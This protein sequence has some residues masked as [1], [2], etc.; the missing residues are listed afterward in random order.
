MSDASIL[1]AALFTPGPRF[2]WGL[3]LRIIGSPGTAKSDIIT[4]VATKA[5]L[6]V[7][8][9]LAS[10]RDPTDFLGMPVVRDGAVT[11]APPDWVSEVSEHKNSAV[12]FDEIN[13]CSPATQ[14]ALLRVVLD[15][16]VGNV[17]LPAT[18]R[19]LAAQNSVDESAGGYDLAMPLANRFGTLTDWTGPNAEEWSEWLVGDSSNDN[20][21]F[22]IGDVEAEQSRVLSEWSL[23]YARATGVISAFIKARP[24][25]LHSQPQANTPQAS[26]PWPSRRTWAMATRAVAA[27]RIHHLAESE[28]DRYIGSFV[29]SAATVELQKFIADLDLPDPAELLDGK[30]SFKYKKERLDRTMA[31]LAACSSLVLPKQATR[32]MER[33]VVLWSILHSIMKDAAD[34]VWPTVKLLCARGVE[35]ERDGKKVNKDADA[36][37]TR[38]HPMLKA[39]GF[40]PDVK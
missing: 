16:V 18:V 2:L 20:P 21:N 9:V 13:T 7:V 27:S 3:P 40:I 32:R 6:H 36:V 14:A 35:L 30:I 37:L 33:S 29:G 34:V 1:K 10:L 5:G 22:E 4:Q 28:S 24:A 31:I 38:F 39:T 26:L 11:Y 19:I 25:L 12:F 17:R 8:V 15:R 23:E